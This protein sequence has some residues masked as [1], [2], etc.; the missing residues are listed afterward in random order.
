MR[1]LKFELLPGHAQTRC[2]NV[3]RDASWIGRVS[4]F[5]PDDALGFETAGIKITAEDLSEIAAFMQTAPTAEQLSIVYQ[6]RRA[7]EFVGSTS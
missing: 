3:M 1:K 2:W 6:T 4:E 5:G 7:Q